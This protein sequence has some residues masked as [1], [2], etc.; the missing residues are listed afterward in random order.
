MNLLLLLNLGVE[1]SGAQA[2]VFVASLICVDNLLRVF[3]ILSFPGLQLHFKTVIE[4]KRVC[5]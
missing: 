4:D 2:T 5:L 3:F 1:Q